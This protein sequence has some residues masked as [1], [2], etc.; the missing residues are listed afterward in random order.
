MQEGTQTD[1]IIMDFAKA[2]EKVPH[3]H[4]CYKLHMYGVRA[5]TLH[6]VQSFR[7]NRSQ[8]VVM[9]EIKSPNTLA[10]PG[11]P[12]GSIL[13]PILLLEFINDLPECFKSDACL[14]TDDTIV[15]TTIKTEEDNDILQQDLRSLER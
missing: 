14:L 13:G 6:W 15:Y 12:Q 11:V 1:A 10:T 4:L 8:C 5:S 3:N 7:Q 9:K 2:F